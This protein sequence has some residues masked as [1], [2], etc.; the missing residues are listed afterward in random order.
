MGV[1]VLELKINK[2][3]VVDI[4]WLRRAV[5]RAEL[6]FRQCTQTPQHIREYLDGVD[7]VQRPYVMLSDFVGPDN[8]DHHMETLRGLIRLIDWYNEAPDY[9][10]IS[11]AE[12]PWTHEVIYKVRLEETIR[13]LIEL[14]RIDRDYGQRCACCEKMSAAPREVYCDPPRCTKKLTVYACQDCW[15]HMQICR[16]C[17]WPVFLEHPYTV[18]VGEILIHLDCF[19]GELTYE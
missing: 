9:V 6:V 4:F 10:H 17:Q 5:Q 3:S 15:D 16:A 1:N 19:D 7:E 13:K 11:A 14:G 2:D 12:W 8:A 18:K